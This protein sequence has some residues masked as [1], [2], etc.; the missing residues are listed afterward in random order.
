MAA[1]SGGGGGWAGRGLRGETRGGR[2]PGAR[3]SEWCRG[4]FSPRVWQQLGPP[5]WEGGHQRGLGSA[6]P[7]APVSETAW[8]PALGVK[9]WL[10]PW[11]LKP[12]PLARCLAPK[13]AAA[14][15][16][17]HAI[18]CP[19]RQPRRRAREGPGAQ[20]GPARRPRSH[21]KLPAGWPSASCPRPRSPRL[22]G[23]G[24]S[25]RGTA[26]RSGRCG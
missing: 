3:A 6:L 21:S 9:P 10:S 22:G 1:G 15:S 24:C 7:P 14:P 25:P 12:L 11:H 23:P 13:G 2:D 8:P 18:S 19:Q 5:V 16:S 26:L 17:H 4:G 20:R